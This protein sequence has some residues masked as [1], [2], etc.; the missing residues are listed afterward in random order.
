MDIKQY[1]GVPMHV[2]LCCLLGL[3]E[4]RKST[5]KEERAHRE[6]D[7]SAPPCQSWM[8]VG[9]QRLWYELETSPHLSIWCIT[10]PEAPAS[11][12]RHKDAGVWTN[13]MRDR[14]SD[15]TLNLD[16]GHSGRLAG[17]TYQRH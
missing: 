7:V 16:V 10:D 17:W 12:P 6:D 1:I 4:G 3:H 9:V 5:Q 13:K 11:Q 14:R 2:L 15:A 8:H